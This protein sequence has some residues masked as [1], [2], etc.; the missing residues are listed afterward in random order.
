M[1]YELIQRIIWVKLT[2]ESAP[3]SA[4]GHLNV[5]NSWNLLRTTNE[6]TKKKNGIL[7]YQINIYDWRIFTLTLKSLLAKAPVG[8]GRIIKKEDQNNFVWT[9]RMTLVI[10]NYFWI[11][12]IILKYLWIIFEC[13]QSVTLLKKI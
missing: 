10:M 4:P 8:E 7:S 3:L 12:F 9:K 11:T 5:T 2:S 13:I 1:N 6:H